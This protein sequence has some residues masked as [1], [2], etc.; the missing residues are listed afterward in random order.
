MDIGAAHTR[1][2]DSQQDF[3]MRGCINRVIPHL[4]RFIGFDQNDSFAHSVGHRKVSSMVCQIRSEPGSSINTRQQPTLS[5][6][7]LHMAPAI[8]HFV[9]SPRRMSKSSRRQ[10]QPHGVVEEAQSKPTLA[11]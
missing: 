4:H 5:S 1:E 9:A 10:G 6:L 3:T 11:A 7:I 2:L 8:E